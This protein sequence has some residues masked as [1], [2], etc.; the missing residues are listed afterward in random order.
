M[1]KV[2]ISDILK[3]VGKK[4]TIDELVPLQEEDDLFKINCTAHAELTVENVGELILVQG[5]VTAEAEVYCIRCN[6]PLVEKLEIKDIEQEYYLEDKLLHFNEDDKKVGLDEFKFVIDERGNIDIE[7]L[8]KQEVILALPIK[9]I[10]N[11][12]HNAVSY[13]TGENK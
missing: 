8:L 9:P 6:S 3:E 12:C 5:I 11:N 10:C 7:D 4:M 1:Y 2:N 13:S